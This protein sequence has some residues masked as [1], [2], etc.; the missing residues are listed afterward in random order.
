MMYA[1]A[2][3]SVEGWQRIRA[4][5]NEFLPSRLRL[6][7]DQRHDLEIVA[8]GH[9]AGAHRSGLPARGR[10]RVGLGL[11]GTRQPRQS[12]SSRTAC[13]GSGS[14]RE[15]PLRCWA[16]TDL[17]WAL[18]DFA[19]A[20]VGA[21][22][23]PIY[24]S[25][26]QRDVQY[27]LEHSRAIG[28][29]VEDDEQRARSARRSRTS[30]P[31]PVWT[32]CVPP[33]GRTQPLTLTRCAS[34]AETI[35]EDDLFTFIYTSG[36]TGP[37]KA[38]MIRHRNY[39]S[40]VEKVDELDERLTLPGDVMLLYLPLAHNYGRLLHSRRRTSVSRSRSCPT[41]CGQPRSCRA[42]ARRS[43][44]ACHASTRRS[45]RPCRAVRRRDGPRR[46]R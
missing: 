26:S 20:L 38:C 22:G 40:M 21:V 33:D 16:R 24:S 30:S 41:R 4:R 10:R 36:T 3:E 35:D 1:S 31:T 7:A 27:V 37:P 29:L 9:R 39:Y 42:C 23:A 32:S 46:A 12:T 14:P 5:L 11:V 2:G 28:A 6:V 13:S 34:A 18:F 43:S 45:T 44:R 8:R 19:L 15:T 25:S 17:E